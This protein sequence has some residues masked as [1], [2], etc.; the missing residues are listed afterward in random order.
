MLVSCISFLPS[1]FNV[2]V[3]CDPELTA[4]F[5]EYLVKSVISDAIHNATRFANSHIV[6]SA[7]QQGKGIQFCVEDDGPG[8]NL[9]IKPESTGLG[10]HFAQLLAAAHRNDGKSGE[11]RISKSN[12]LGGARF[13]LYLP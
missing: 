10:I 12:E 2:N 1:Q 3:I 11:V 5:D 8:F 7:S 4:Y 6:I 13:I 9:D